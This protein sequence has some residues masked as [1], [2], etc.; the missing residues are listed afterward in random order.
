MEKVF[1]FI[2]A[3]PTT[4][5][6]KATET[7]DATITTASTATR[8]SSNAR[9]SWEANYSWEDG[10]DGTFESQPAPTASSSDVPDQA[11]KAFIAELM[12]TIA[13]LGEKLQEKDHRIAQ[14]E[15]EKKEADVENVQLK[16]QLESLCWEVNRMLRDSNNSKDSND[17]SRSGC[18]A[19]KN[20]QRL[21]MAEI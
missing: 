1:Q 12:E 16:E 19:N 5:N 13:D 3:P 14:L 15:D 9:Y 2:V 4:D 6:T 18:G 8:T 20:R 11:S 21:P 7:D 17:S 10:E